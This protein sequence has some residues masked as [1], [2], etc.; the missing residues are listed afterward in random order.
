LVNTCS[1]ANVAHWKSIGRSDRELR[2]FFWNLKRVLAVNRF[3][4]VGVAGFELFED[5]LAA[6]ASENQ[7]RIVVA[8]DMFRQFTVFAVELWD[9]VAVTTMETGGRERHAE[10]VGLWIRTR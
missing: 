3:F 7:K 8:P 4:L 10:D 6:I 1:E 9:R 2:H 5:L